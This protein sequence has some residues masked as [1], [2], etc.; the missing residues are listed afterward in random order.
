MLRDWLPGSG[1]Q[2]GARPMFEHYPIDATYDGK[3]GEFECE[4]CIPVTPL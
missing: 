2:L 1:M 4:I 3:T